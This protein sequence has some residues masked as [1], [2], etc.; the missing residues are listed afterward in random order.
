MRKEEKCMNCKQYRA[1]LVGIIAIV[2]LCGMF[3]FVKYAKEN[4]IPSD[5]TLV[6]HEQEWDG[7]TEWA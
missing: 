6:R 2:L 5:G 1:C 3:N 7:M 4:Q